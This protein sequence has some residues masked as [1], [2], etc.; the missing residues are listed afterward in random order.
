MLSFAKPT[1][2]E[3]RDYLWSLRKQPFTY[4]HV[5]RTR[6]GADHTPGGFSC[7]HQRALLGHGQACYQRAKRALEQWRMFPPEFV[8]LVWPC[9]LEADRIVATLFRAPG[10]WTVNPCRIVYTLDET[11]T[12]KSRFGFAYGTIGK[13]LASGEERFLVEHNEDD[14]SVWYEV[15]CFSKVNHWLSTLAYPY[16]RAQQHRFRAFSAEA[17]QRAVTETAGTPSPASQRDFHRNR[18]RRSIEVTHLN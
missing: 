17:M 6:H 2:S 14:D 5:G 3:L 7:G 16:L 11:N 10:F 1:Y 15:Y 13:H 18:V 12:D 9:P 8:D 4:E